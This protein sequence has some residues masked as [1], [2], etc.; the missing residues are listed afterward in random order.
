M[1]IEIMRIQTASKTWSKNGHRSARLVKLHAVCHIYMSHDV[2]VS[3][4]VEL[5]AECTC[6][7][8]QLLFATSWS[9]G[10]CC[11][12][13]CALRDTGRAVFFLCR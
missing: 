8:N 6:H 4:Q 11:T 2:D 3:R 5:A 9:P 7:S 13:A 10:I 12:A 1:D